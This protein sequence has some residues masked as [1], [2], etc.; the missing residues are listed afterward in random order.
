MTSY[1]AIY[2]KKLIHKSHSLRMNDLVDDSLV[3]TDKSVQL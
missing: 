1:L 2:T 3:L